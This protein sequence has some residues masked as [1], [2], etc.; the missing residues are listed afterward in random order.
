M[1]L[2]VFPL[3]P[4]LL[5]H[6]PLRKAQTVCYM[7]STLV[8]EFFVKSFSKICC[9]VSNKRVSKEGRKY[10]VNTKVGKRSG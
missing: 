4:S 10:Y 3:G 7:P 9:Q 8:T 5:Q 6:F 2:K 1:P